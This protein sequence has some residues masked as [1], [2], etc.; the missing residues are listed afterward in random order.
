[1]RAQEPDWAGLRR[2]LREP[3]PRYLDA[4]LHPGEPVLRGPQLATLYG[5]PQLDVEG[6]K[7]LV[8]IHLEQPPRPGGRLHDL[9][10][11]V[12]R[13]VERLLHQHM[14][15]GGQ[16]FQ[17]D[18]TM[19]EVRRHHRDAVQIFVLDHRAVIRVALHVELRAPL[20]EQVRVDLGKRDRPHPS[21]PSELGEG[22]QVHQ[23]E[24]PA[25]NDPDVRAHGV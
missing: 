10:A 19:Q 4:I 24:L 8:E 9:S 6:V 25:A 1:M 12:R 5:L 17:G 21:I 14:F 7:A 16:A 20:L 22:A 3:V 18:G 23:A 2:P 15:A 13:R 11:P